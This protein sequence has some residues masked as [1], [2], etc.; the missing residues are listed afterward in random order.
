[1]AITGWH[2]RLNTTARGGGE[3]SRGCRDMTGQYSLP[4]AKVVYIDGP[5]IEAR[6]TVAPT[7]NNS[8]YW[9]F[10]TG[11]PSRPNRQRGASM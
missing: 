7:L 9:E 1:M 4:E 8:G 2:N 3:Y 10:N 5:Y 11:M 6:H